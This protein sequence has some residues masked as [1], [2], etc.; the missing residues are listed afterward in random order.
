MAIRKLRPG[1]IRVAVLSRI[2][3]DLE[4]LGLTLEEGRKL[5][6]A[7]QSALV[8][9]QAE[10]WRF[11]CRI[12]SLVSNRRGASN[13]AAVG[14][15][16]PPLETVPIHS[17]VEFLSRQVLQRPR[18]ALSLRFGGNWSAH[19]PCPSSRRAATSS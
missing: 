9:S 5:L 7:A 18:R 4:L 8:A 11:T 15:A 12:S 3:D 1:P 2:D 6:A 16:T 14:L 19:G 10:Q 17:R 13:H